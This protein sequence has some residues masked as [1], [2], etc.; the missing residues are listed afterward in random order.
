M[1]H[2]FCYR[3]VE[4]AHSSVMH[5]V[6]SNIFFKHSNNLICLK[7]KTNFL[8]LILTYFFVYVCF[9]YT[10]A[11]K[12]VIQSDHQIITKTLSSIYAMF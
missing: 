9:K 7:Y 3:F 10:T 2:Y 12:I 1:L 5:L 4:L 6:N 8:N 11:L